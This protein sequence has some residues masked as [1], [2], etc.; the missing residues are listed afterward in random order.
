[1][2]P[3]TGRYP[4]ALRAFGSNTKEKNT[5]AINA[6]DYQS[7]LADYNSQVQAGITKAYIEQGY[8]DTDGKVDPDLLAD[9]AY[10]VVTSRTVVSKDDKNDPLKSITRG[11]LFVEL[12]PT[13]P[14]AD[15][16]HP[17]DLD[18]VD[19]AVYKK[20]DRDCWGLT[21]DAP[22]GKIQRRLDDEGS[23]LVLCRSSMMRGPNRLEGVFVTDEAQFILGDNLKKELDALQ[24][25]AETV[26][27]RVEMLSDRHP[28]LE[29]QI[30][31]QL[32]ATVGRVQAALPGAAE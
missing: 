17:D 14:G 30:Q 9:A 19:H 11:E 8:V 12:F 29:D 27:R 31:G 21:Q 28:E 10:E 13:A 25:K 16:T 15:G 6:I 32:A 3:A 26:Q 1:M 20:L 5:M 7:V 4:F 24:K 18:P 23:S 22:S 2:F